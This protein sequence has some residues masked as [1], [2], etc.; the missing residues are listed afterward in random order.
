MCGSVRPPPAGEA[1]SLTPCLSKSD[2]YPHILY[3]PPLKKLPLA[4]NPIRHVPTYL[5]FMRVFNSKFRFIR[6]GLI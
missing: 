2:K 4:I 1:F 3:Y 6:I 5:F